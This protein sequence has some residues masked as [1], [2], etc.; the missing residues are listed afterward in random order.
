MQHLFRKVVGTIHSRLF[1]GC[2]EG[3]DGTVLQRLVFHDSQ[4][5][6][7][8]ESVVG[9]ECR[10]LGLHPLTVNPSLDRVGFEV[11]G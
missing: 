9:T 7:H 3:F 6:C 2:D 5:G 10:V 11:M 1:I 8:T 4:D